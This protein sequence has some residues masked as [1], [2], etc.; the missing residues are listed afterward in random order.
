MTAVVFAKKSVW[1]SVAIVR[2]Y[3]RTILLCPSLDVCATP[4]RGKMGDVCH[5]HMY[6]PLLCMVWCIEMDGRWMCRS[7][8]TAREYIDACICTCVS[9]L[10]PPSSLSGRAFMCSL[11]PANVYLLCISGSLLCVSYSIAVVVL[12]SRS[13]TWVL[14]TSRYK[15][16]GLG[17]CCCWLVDL[18]FTSQRL[19][20]VCLEREKSMRKSWMQ[21]LDAGSALYVKRGK[22]C[23]LVLSGGSGE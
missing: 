14:S 2:H 7:P 6:M 17:W 5:P 19:A 13:T 1:A 18:Q 8:L 11:L 3:S 15:C 9:L 12:Y 10:Q 4:C 20:I 23:I 16:S 22:M 21:V